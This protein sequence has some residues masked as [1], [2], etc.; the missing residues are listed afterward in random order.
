[1]ST[2]RERLAEEGFESNEDYDFTVRCLFNTETRGVRALNIVGEG[3]RRKTAFATALARALRIP[4]ILYHDFSDQHPPLPDV[5]LPPSRDE[6]GRED[7][8]I[9]PLDRIVSEAC[10]QSEGET[11]VLILDQ[12]HCA[13]F[14]EHIRIH[15]LISSCRWEVRDGHY[16]ANPYHLL[17]FLISEDPLYHA[18]HKESFR[19]W[20]S[21]RSHKQ[22]VYRP[23]DFG[24]DEDA[25]PLF[26]ALGTLFRALNTAPTPSEFGHL[27][28]DLRLQTRTT[29][30]LRLALFGRTEGLERDSLAEP[31]LEL[32]LTA[33][34]Q[35][36]HALF[37]TESI[38]I[39][40]E[41]PSDNPSTISSTPSNRSPR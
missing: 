3:E 25:R 34:L 11:T 32:A 35:T 7:P 21:R 31:N 20:I 14:R 1:M 13:D 39:A 17:V 38:E 2:L 28:N 33:V 41:A 26:E 24:L 29:E 37:V 9:E 15:R 6:L 8:P 16:Y 30:D 36:A 27:L 12:L 5:I 10:A 23:Q 19:V 4:H 18:L 22:I 40:G